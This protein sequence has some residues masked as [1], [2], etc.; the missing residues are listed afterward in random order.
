[1]GLFSKKPIEGDGWSFDRSRGQ[2]TISGDLGDKS[3]PFMSIQ[4]DVRTVVA[5]KGSS[6]RNCS[7]MFSDMYKLTDADLS[8]LDVSECKSMFNMFGNCRFLQKLDLSNMD[9]GSVEDISAMT[10]GCASLETLNLTGWHIRQ[11]AKTEGALSE[12]PKTVLIYT[13]DASVIALLPE[14]VKPTPYG[15]QSM[16]FNTAL[17]LD[18]AGD[19]A[20]A[21]R[22][23]KLVADQGSLSALWNLSILYRNGRGVEKDVNMATSL[24]MQAAE[25]GHAMAM[26]T[27]A[28]DYFFGTAGLEKDNEK[29]LSLSMKAKE[30]GDLTDDIPVDDLIRRIENDIAFDAARAAKA[31]GDYAEANRQY[32]IAIDK[33]SAA[34]AWNLSIMYAKGE[35]VPKDPEECYKLRFKAAKM[36]NARAMF[37]MAERLHYGDGIPEKNDLAA[38]HWANKAKNNK[39]LPADKAID[40]LIQSI[41]DSL[42]E[43]MGDGPDPD[44]MAAKMYSDGEVVEQDKLLALHHYARAAESGDPDAISVLLEMDHEDMFKTA[45]AAFDAGN[46]KGAL[47]AY[48]AAFRTYIMRKNRNWHYYLFYSPFYS[49]DYKKYYTQS[50]ELLK[51]DAAKGNS[52]AEYYLGW[53]YWGPPEHYF[54]WEPGQTRDAEPLPADP[55]AAVPHYEK[56]LEMGCDQALVFM[57]ARYYEGDYASIPEDREKVLE[58]LSRAAESSDP[59]VRYEA[60]Y[61]YWNGYRDSIGGEIWGKNPEK[62]MDIMIEL[63][64][65]GHAAAMYTLYRMYDPRESEYPN[66]SEKMI[67]YLRMAAQHGHLYSIKL[68]SELEEALDKQTRQKLI[69]SF[70]ERAEVYLYGWDGVEQDKDKAIEILKSIADESAEAAK[71]LGEFYFL[72]NDAEAEKWFIKAAEQGNKNVLGILG[73]MYYNGSIIPQDKAEAVKWYKKAAEAGDRDILYDLA[74]MYYYGDGIPVNKKEAA[75]WYEKAAELG[76]YDAQFSLGTMYGE[77]DGIYKDISIAIKWYK[78][79]AE[80]GHTYAMLNLGMIAF[81]GSTLIDKHT[82]IMWIKQAA[83]QGNIDAMCELGFI[84]Q[85]GDYGTRDIETAKRYYQQAADHGSLR[86][87]DAL[88]SLNK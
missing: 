26:F 1:M 76:D 82:G 24:R 28:T 87:I 32:R 60:A 7:G 54:H 70:M 65:S 33:G 18:N 25:Q 21:A 77:G 11:G 68:V 2:L 16:R 46:R 15:S 6:A 48:H 66:D 81:N 78:K 31:K 14:G 73:E 83:E 71:K 8:E 80:Q 45:A 64:E 41:H 37:Y 34:A 86:A 17:A 36:G 29:A 30:S 74:E 52:R 22:Q 55:F 56:A 67:E 63:A 20:E 44:Y 88:K 75:K 79:A 53:L 49:K 57:A 62:A 3:K 39:N 58:L 51:E 42:L 47:Y 19:Y 84:Y 12:L 50:I 61:R 9:L 27:V 13:D 69:E 4:K 72:R 43:N 38:L 35:G 40:Q 10:A 5:L 85:H 23:Y 59:E